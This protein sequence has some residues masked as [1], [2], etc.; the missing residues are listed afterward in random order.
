MTQVIAAVTQDYVLL[1]ADRR[2]TFLDGP[3][4][5]RLVDDDTCKLV[6]LCNTSGIG[7]TGLAQI[8]GAPAH[9]WV[10][11]VL[12]SEQ[13]SDPGLASRVLAKRASSALRNLSPTVRRQTFVLVGWAEFVN[14][15]GLRSYITV[16]T[17]MADG[18]GR[19]LSKPNQE[20]A[21]LVS[22]RRDAEDLK[23][24]VADSLCCL[25]GTR[26]SSAIFAP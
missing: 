25:G 1:V 16:V 20:F 13:C 18:T 5:G 24:L 12:A 21:V 2:L 10:A 15:A 8:E 6:S 7:Y 22:A 4:P 19:P 11:K 17:N 26:Y 9:E 23:I 14:L 3:R